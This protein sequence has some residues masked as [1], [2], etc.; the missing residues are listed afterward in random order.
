MAFMWKIGSGVIIRSPSSVS[1][2][3]PPAPA[4]QRPASRK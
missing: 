1:A 2:Q 4:Y 3:T